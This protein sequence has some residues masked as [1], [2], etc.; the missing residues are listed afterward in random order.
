MTWKATSVVVIGG[1]SGIGLAVAREAAQRGARTIVVGRSRDKLAAAHE[2]LGV[3]TIA[4]DVTREADIVRMF[5]QTGVVDHVVVT[6]ATAGYAP[7]AEL[8]EATARAVIDGKLVSAILLAKHAR[9]HVRGS[10]TLTSGIAKDRPKPGGAVLAAVNAALGTLA[11]ALAIELAPTRVNVVSP[12]WVDTPIWDTI[13]GD[14]KA[15]VWDE[16]ARKLPVRRI[17]TP[18]ELAAA[19]TFLIENGFATGTTVHVDGGH[20]LV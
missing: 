14:R 4:A 7:I 12:G 20:A 16:L 2:S 3:E 11:R 13:A 18:A 6:S 5:E 17:G 1:S 8:A 10:L 19:Y 9:A 15:A